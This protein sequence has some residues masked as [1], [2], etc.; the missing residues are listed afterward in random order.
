MNR[1]VLIA[2]GALVVLGIFAFLFN[3]FTASPLEPAAQSETTEIVDSESAVSEDGLENA[4][5]GGEAEGMPITSVAEA[6]QAIDDLDTAEL[7]ALLAADL[8]EIE[9]SF[10]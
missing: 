4:L 7:D 6:V 3:T 9:A 8:A 1:M 2:A 5:I 10:E